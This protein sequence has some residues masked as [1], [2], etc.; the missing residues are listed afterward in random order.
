MPA[1]KAARDDSAFHNAGVEEKNHDGGV[2]LDGG[3]LGSSGLYQV[4]RVLQI[5]LFERD[6]AAED[7]GAPR[8]P[9]LP[10]GVA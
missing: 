10:A 4:G 3:E 6:G 1:A 9:A 8:L 5:G 2:H 7:A